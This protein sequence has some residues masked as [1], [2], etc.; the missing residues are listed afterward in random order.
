MFLARCFV[1]ERFG[2]GG[3]EPGTDISPVLNVISNRYFFEKRKK[4]TLNMIVHYFVCQIYITFLYTFNV[5]YSKRHAR[6]AS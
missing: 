2:L 6:R 5:I 4:L 1:A 3:R